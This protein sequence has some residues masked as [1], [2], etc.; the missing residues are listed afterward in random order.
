MVQSWGGGARGVVT[1]ARFVITVEVGWKRL[2]GAV[3][4]RCGLPGAP[5]EVA[6][7]IPVLEEEQL[8]NSS[9]L[10][11]QAQVLEKRNDR[12]AR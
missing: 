1:G 9:A 3:A 10:S 11:R 2:V 5:V 6:F 12:S 4:V 8:M 7:E